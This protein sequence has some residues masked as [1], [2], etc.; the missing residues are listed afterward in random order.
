MTSSSLHF[1]CQN[2][3]EL[4]GPE[5]PFFH[6]V[7]D[8]RDVIVQLKMDGIWGRVT[9]VDSKVKVYSKTH[10]QKREFDL[11]PELFS[12]PDQPTVLI[13]EFMYGSQ[14][15]KHPDRQGLLYVFD[16]VVHRGEDLS[17]TRYAERYRRASTVCNQLGK[18]FE[19][20]PCYSFSRWGELWHEVEATKREGLVFH[21]W[22]SPYNT[23]LYKLKLEVED[24]FVVM[25][26][27]EGQ[28]QHVG[29]LGSIIAGQYNDQGV[30][31]RVGEI[32]GGYSTS[33]RIAIWATRTEL[34]GRVFLAKGKGRFESGALRHPNFGHF[35]DDK[36]PS[37][38][39]LK[40]T[41]K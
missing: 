1:E 34:L 25:G 23:T 14:W 20:V 40:R 2:Y 35:R 15:S 36:L 8:P 11:H 10:Q 38:C 28:N 7:S 22:S 24:D 41:S 33:D 26:Y 5:D 37:Q 39:I 12:A 17:S 19:M 27:I 32:G 13:A 3:V 16:C 4:S 18:P 9:I 6:E 21:R 31:V 30:L 29:R